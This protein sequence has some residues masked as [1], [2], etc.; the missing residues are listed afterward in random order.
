M[1]VFRAI[2]VPLVSERENLQRPSIVSSYR[3][4]TCL[5]WMAEKVPIGVNYG[6]SLVL[7]RIVSAFVNLVDF[8]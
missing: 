1:Q 5:V 3:K 2:L 8:P 6:K 7:L 4:M